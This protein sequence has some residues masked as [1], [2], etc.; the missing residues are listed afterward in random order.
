MEPLSET[1]ES[2]EGQEY[3]KIRFIYST[4]IVRDIVAGTKVNWNLAGWPA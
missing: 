1:T 4:I 3:E 2:V